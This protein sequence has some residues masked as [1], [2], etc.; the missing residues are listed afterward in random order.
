[1]NQILQAANIKIEGYWTTLFARALEGQDIGTLLT[2]VGSGAGA[3]MG[4][5]PVATEAQTV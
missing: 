5:A 4:G 1:M 2:N 3:A